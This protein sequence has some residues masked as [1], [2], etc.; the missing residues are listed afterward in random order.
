MYSRSS[1]VLM[2]DGGYCAR[3]VMFLMK[4]GEFGLHIRGR[5]LLEV[6]KGTGV[7]EWVKQDILYVSKGD[8]Y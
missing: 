3:R 5:A 7:G 8:F 2:K 4:F 1:R 6:A